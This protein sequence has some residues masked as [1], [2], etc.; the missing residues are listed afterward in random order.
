MKHFRKLLNLFLAVMVT[1]LVLFSSC[2]KDEVVTE[3]V[4]S[5]TTVT[6][7]IS[8]IDAFSLSTVEELS[9]GDDTG[10]KSATISDCLSVSIH[11]LI[12]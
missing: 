9:T 5:K 12:V 4:I 10:L 3:D 8:M 2:N 7:Y 1:S 6:D 11:E